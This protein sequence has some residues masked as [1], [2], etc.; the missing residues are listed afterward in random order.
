MVAQEVLVLPR[1]CA[2]NS[3]LVRSSSACLLIDTGMASTLASFNAALETYSLSIASITHVAA[4]HYHPDHIGLIPRLVSYGVVP[5]A[6]GNQI[7][8]LH[9]SDEIYMRSPEEP[10]RPIEDNNV[11]SVPFEQSRSFLSSLGIKGEVL[12]LPSHSPDSIGIMLDTKEAFVGDLTPLNWIAITDDNPV[13][14]NWKSILEYKPNVIYYG[15][16]P[17]LTL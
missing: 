12:S 16:A 2:T 17:A 11:I 3:Y 1:Y 15:H 4:T 6:F 7:Q 10:F 14:D 13:S 9:D 5:I 8:H